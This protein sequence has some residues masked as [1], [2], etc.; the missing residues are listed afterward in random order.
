MRAA[1]EPTGQRVTQHHA[2]EV[3]GEDDRGHARGLTEHESELPRP[4]HL[5]GQ[6]HRARTE[7]QAVHAEHPRGL[8]LRLLG[9]LTAAL[10]RFVGAV[11]T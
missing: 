2:Q 11:A 3:A 8:S 4:R 10:S 1:T 9:H 6:T 7:D 5:V